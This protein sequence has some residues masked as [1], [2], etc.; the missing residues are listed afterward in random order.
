MKVR[1]GSS[2]E[3]ARLTLTP[4]DLHAFLRSRRSI[5]RFKADLVP[6]AAIER[7]I[8]TATFAPSAHHRQPWRFAVLT[9]S[10]AKTRLA[11]RM[12]E[13]FSAE[14]QR[15][16]LN[17][18]DIDFQ[19]HRSRAKIVA[20]PAI[21]VVSL[22]MTDMDSYAD[23]RRE[24]IE[25]LMAVQSV[26]NATMQLQLAAH[27]EGLASVWVCSPLFAQEAVR[28]ALDLPAPWQPQAMLFL[29]YAALTP[30]PRPRKPLSEI[31]K[32]I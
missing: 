23:A 5:R 4:T 1:S 19:V 26:A 31:V 6:A 24:G 11:D 16:G 29:G 15:D 20:A 28:I 2:T 10:S 7:I 17:K 27:A 32:S 30:E 12:A 18:E 13:D 21:V 3:S 25:H 8:T 22:D 14:L 9:D